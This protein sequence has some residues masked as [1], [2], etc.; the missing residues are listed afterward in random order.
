M[1]AIAFLLAR[2]SEPSSYAG[3][4]AVLAMAGFHFSDS[5]LGQAAQFLAAGCGLAALFLKERG[6]IQMIVLA[7]LVATTL[8]AC[9]G[10]SQPTPAAVQAGAQAVLTT[11]EQA[12]CQAQT[13]ANLAGAVAAAAGDAA[14]AADASKASAAAGIG[15]TWTNA[16]QA[17]PAAAAS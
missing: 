7:L 1:Q 5:V 9:A 16:P 8:G 15:C 14:A 11:T 6:M 12:M 10:A 13:V 2:F 17:A 4:G 3:L